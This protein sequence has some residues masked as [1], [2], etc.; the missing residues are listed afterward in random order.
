VTVEAETATIAIDT[1]IPLGM[2]VN[3]LVTNAI[4]YAHGPGERGRIHVRFVREA[5]DLILTVSDDGRGLPSEVRSKSSG[6]GMTMVRSLVL[7]VGGD[8]T[9]TQGPGA[10]FTIRLPVV[11]TAR[12]SDQAKVH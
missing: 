12:P 9:V 10:A 7:Q 2:V 11:A 4:K 5:T 8:L 3:E 6:L 1:A